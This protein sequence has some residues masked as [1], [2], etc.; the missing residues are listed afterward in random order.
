MEENQKEVDETNER[1]LIRSGFVALIVMN[2]IE[3]AG[4]SVILLR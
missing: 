1:R 2:F 3:V 4:I